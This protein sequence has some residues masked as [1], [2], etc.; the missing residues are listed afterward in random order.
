MTVHVANGIL[1][2]APP[3]PTRTQQQ[4]NT[5]GKA[6]GAAGA[7][8]GAIVGTRARS[9]ELGIPVAREEGQQVGGVTVYRMGGAVT[10]LP[11]IIRLFQ[12]AP[13]PQGLTPKDRRCVLGGDA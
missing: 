9:S 13:S 7:A 11:L 12:Q 10:S 4:K 6:K 1:D 3:P 8:V 2:A 5:Y